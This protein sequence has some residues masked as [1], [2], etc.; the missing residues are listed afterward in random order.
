[1]EGS[2]QVA[3]KSFTVSVLLKRLNSWPP[4]FHVPSPMTEFT[5]RLKESQAFFPV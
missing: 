3:S 5:A 2:P 1:M 4:A